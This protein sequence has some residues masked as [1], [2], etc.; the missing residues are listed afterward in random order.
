MAAGL[1]LMGGVQHAAA[2]PWTWLQ[3]THVTMNEQMAAGKYGGR[4]LS[5]GHLHR[6]WP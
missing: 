3:S 2:L 4:C 5:V 1:G 6:V